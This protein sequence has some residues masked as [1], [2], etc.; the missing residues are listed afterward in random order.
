M[1]DAQEIFD[2]QDIY[3]SAKLLMELHGPS[4]WYVAD[5]RSLDCF[6]IGLETEAMAW[7]NIKVVINEMN[8]KQ[9]LAVFQIH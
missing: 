1:N 4:A 6:E 7:D 3:A 5:K 8:V 9:K 2:F